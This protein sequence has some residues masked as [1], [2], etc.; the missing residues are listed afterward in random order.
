[1][2]LTW[3]YMTGA[4]DG[5]RTRTVSLGIARIWAVLAADVRVRP[6]VSDRG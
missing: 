2:A 3:H 6:A 5:N 1:M 4:G